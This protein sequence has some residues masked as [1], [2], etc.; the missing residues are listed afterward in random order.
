[1]I[2]R[3]LSDKIEIKLYK[4]CPWSKEII[5]FKGLFGLSK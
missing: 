5:F 4:G 3:F 1:M 2:G